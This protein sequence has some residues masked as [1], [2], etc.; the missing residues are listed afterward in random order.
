MARFG[1][2]GA[3]A[4]HALWLETPTGQTRTVVDYAA[5]PRLTAR[6]SAT[7]AFAVGTSLLRIKGK[8]SNAAFP[9]RPVSSAAARSGRAAALVGITEFLRSGDAAATNTLVAAAASDKHLQATAPTL[10]KRLCRHGPGGG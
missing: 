8:G 2:H 4:L 10:G 9:Q 7:K 1:P 3:A 6:V 5:S